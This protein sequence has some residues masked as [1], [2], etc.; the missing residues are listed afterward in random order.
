MELRPPDEGE[1]THLV[2]RVIVS[3][4]GGRFIPVDT[5]PL[6][7]EVDEGDVI[8]HVEVSGHELV[9]VSSPFRGHLVEMCAWRGERL[10]P[11]QRVAW[12]RAS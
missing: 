7:G 4:V 11:Q 8:G 12:L 9:P 2:E 1:T 3:P 5:A 10:Q 6:C